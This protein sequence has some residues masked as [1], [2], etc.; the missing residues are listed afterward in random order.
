[1]LEFKEANATSQDVEAKGDYLAYVSADSFGADAVHIEQKIGGDWRRYS[2]L[3]FTA[4]TGGQVVP[5]NSGTKVRVVTEALVVNPVVVL[6]L[7]AKRR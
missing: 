2:N 1:M 5:C 6:Q 4:S 3:S 7:H